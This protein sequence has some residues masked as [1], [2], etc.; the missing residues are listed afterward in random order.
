LHYKQK[1]LILATSKPDVQEKSNFMAVKKSE[2]YS[3]IWECCNQLRGGMDAS[4][5]KDYVLVVLFVK[6]ISDR[7]KSVD[8]YLIEVPEGASFDDLVKLKG[9]ANISEEFNKILNKIAEANDLNG[10]INVADFNDEAKLGKGKDL[11][12]TVS[13]LIGAFQKPELDFANNRADNDDLLGDAY[14]YLMKHF[15][16]ESGKSKGQF[17]TP[18]EVSRVMAKVIGIHL[19]N[20]ILVNL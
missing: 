13:N 12:D 1:I 20:Q 11:V 18:A 15:A 9:K 3:S 19:D 10:V 2:L 7:A 6:Y 17:Y 14:E 8:G 4:Q 16:S 5:Y